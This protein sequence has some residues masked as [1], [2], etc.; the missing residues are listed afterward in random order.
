MKHLMYCVILLA[1][2]AGCLSAQ[3]AFWSDDF[4][5]GNQ[6]WTLDN[7]WSIADGEL[8]LSWSPSIT[9]YDL[10]AVSPVI[11]LPSNVGDVVLSQYLDTYSPEDE[12]IEIGLIIN[13]TLTPLWDYA[14]VGGDWGSSG[15]ESLTL[16]LVPYAGQDA[17][18]Y[19]RSYGASTYNLDYWHIFEVAMY[20][21]YDNDMRAEVV[22]G[23]PNAAENAMEMWKVKVSNCG[24]NP[25]SAY[26]IKLYKDM[27]VE[28]ASLDVYHPLQCTESAEFSFFWTPATTQ[29]TQLYGTVVL[30]GDECNVNDSTPELGVTIFPEGERQYLVWDYD[31]GSEYTSP[32]NNATLHCEHSI[33]DPLDANGVNY[34]LVDELPAVLRNYNTVFVALG[35]Y[36]VG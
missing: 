35:L 22:L 18:L 8:K 13:G 16:S 12:M 34:Q 26:Q 23:P 24:V 21:M 31:N 5:A 6:G 32:D 3:S 17:Q 25:Q 30:D 14:A 9:N 15:G 19:F 20:A 11:T 36:C 29:P 28:I 10:S 27:G 2:F 7:N 4:S 33:I 1:L